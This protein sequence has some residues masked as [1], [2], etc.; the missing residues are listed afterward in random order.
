MRAECNCSTRNISPGNSCWI[1]SRSS[2][3]ASTRYS[4]SVR[5]ESKRQNN[6][7]WTP[8]RRRVRLPRC[9]LALGRQAQAVVTDDK[10]RE[11]PGPEPAERPRR[12]QAVNEPIERFLE[13]HAPGLAFP[14]A[15]DQGSKAEG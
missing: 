9:A 15:I 4:C 3:I 8:G 14:D 13:D 6:K 5:R 10:V 11:S 1:S 2:G 7:K 12:Q